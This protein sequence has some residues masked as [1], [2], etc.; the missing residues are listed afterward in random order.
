[1][2]RHPALSKLSDKIAYNNKVFASLA[3]RFMACYEFLDPLAD[4]F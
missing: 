3:I 2:L 1:M 4:N